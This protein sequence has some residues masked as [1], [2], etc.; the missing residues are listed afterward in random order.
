MLKAVPVGVRLKFGRSGLAGPDDYGSQ[1][2][3]DISR[4][5]GGECVEEPWGG[6]VEAVVNVGSW[7]TI[8]R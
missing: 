2:A 4:V 7:V 6:G 5:I 1:L 3:A 8:A